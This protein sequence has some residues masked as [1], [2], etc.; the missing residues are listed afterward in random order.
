MSRGREYWT[1][2]EVEGQVDAK[3][4]GVKREG[5]KKGKKR[6]HTEKE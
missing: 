4:D 2:K 6:I 5:A 1:A 3:G